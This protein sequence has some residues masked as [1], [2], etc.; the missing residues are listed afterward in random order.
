MRVNLKKTPQE[1]AAPD[2]TSL[3]ADNDVKQFMAAS[4]TELENWVNAVNSFATLR[5]ILLRVAKAILLILLILQ[6]RQ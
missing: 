2:I 6:G 3:L 1:K 5:P 4:S